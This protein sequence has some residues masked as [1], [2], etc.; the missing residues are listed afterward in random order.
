M[1][2]NILI[3]ILLVVFTGVTFADVVVPPPP[4]NIDISSSEFELLESN[5]FRI[6][7]LTAPAYPGVY[8]VDFLWNSNE[9]IFQ[10]TAVDNDT[11]VGVSGYF[12]I[13]TTMDV[14][15]PPPPI[16]ID[17]SYSSF[18]VLAPNKFG[19]RNLTSPFNPGNYQVDF[20]WDPNQLIFIPIKIDID[21]GG[22]TYEKVSEKTFRSVDIKYGC[23]REGT[24]PSDYTIKDGVIFIPADSGKTTFTLLK[25]ETD[26]YVVQQT[27]T[28]GTFDEQW[29]EESRL[30]GN[31][32]CVD[33]SQLGSDGATEIRN[34]VLQNG[35]WDCT[36]KPDG[37]LTCPDATFDG[38]WWVADGL[39]YFDHPEGSDLCIDAKA[40]QVID[41]K[42][43]FATNANASRTYYWY[44]VN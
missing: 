34:W 42:L 9:L 32:S 31:S 21:S 1:K 13:Y 39:F 19:A 25:E 6:R 28:G 37:T 27:Y 14:V 2:R 26:R 4:I 29:V 43:Y 38:S 33:A 15:V 11:G 16:D 44:F 10:P 18:E 41:S 40:Y 22:F 12:D 24:L 35:L 8:W 30:C 23:E 20:L 17:I 3:F 5:K 7:N 36:V